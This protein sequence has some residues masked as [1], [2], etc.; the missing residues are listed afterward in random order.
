VSLV[1]FLF[2]FVFSLFRSSPS[3]FFLTFFHISFSLF[4][5]LP[6]T[7]S[8]ISFASRICSLTI[9]SYHKFL[10]IVFLLLSLSLSLFVFLLLFLFADFLLFDCL[11]FMSLSFLFPVVPVSYISSW[12]FLCPLLH[13][14]VENSLVLSVLT[15]YSFAAIV[16]TLSDGIL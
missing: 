9:F 2:F 11:F 6:S 15:S 10:F 5:L 1:T 12:L 7:R 8:L 4:F 16:L 14:A 13:V 3:F